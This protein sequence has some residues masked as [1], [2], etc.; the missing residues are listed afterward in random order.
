MLSKSAKQVLSYLKSREG[1]YILRQARNVLKA[2]NI[3]VSDDDQMGIKSF[4][5]ASALYPNA[6]EDQTGGLARYAGVDIDYCQVDSSWCEG[7]KN[8]PRYKMPV[9]EGKVLHE[10]V[11]NLQNGLID[12]KKIPKNPYEARYYELHGQMK[13]VDGKTPKDANLYAYHEKSATVPGSSIYKVKVS[14]PVEIDPTQLKPTQ[15]EINF[16]KSYGMAIGF[17]KGWKGLVKYD[18]KTVSLVSK[19]GYIID[20]HHRWAA[21]CMLNRFGKEFLAGDCFLNGENCEVSAPNHITELMELVTAHGDTSQAVIDLLKDAP[22]KSAGLKMPVI[23]IEL[24]VKQLVDVLNACTDSY[25]IARKPFDAKDLDKV[26][27]PLG[28]GYHFEKAEI[29]GDVEPHEEFLKEK[30]N[31]PEYD[32]SNPAHNKTA[33]LRRRLNNV[34]L[35][36]K[37]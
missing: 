12:W 20:G 9:I 2:N 4:I 1:S 6:L 7:N 31:A 34:S 30:E 29:E 18:P 35:Y 5:M 17:V 10:V 37:S 13:L 24:P 25:G 3:R 15:S 11:K 14:E 28:E 36:R 19:E 32:P 23:I 33:H 21:I 22:K 8:I 27:I 16:D 26:K